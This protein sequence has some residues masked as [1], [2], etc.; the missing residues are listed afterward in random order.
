[1]LLIFSLDMYSAITFDDSHF[2]TSIQIEYW[3]D[4]PSVRKDFPHFE[5]NLALTIEIARKQK[6]KIIWVR[7]DYRKHHR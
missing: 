5:E 1:M 6:A 7:A 4:C 2:S 3:T